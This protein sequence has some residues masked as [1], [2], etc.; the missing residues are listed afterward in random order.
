MTLNNMSITTDK[1]SK[2]IE[3]LNSYIGGDFFL[4]IFGQIFKSVIKQIQPKKCR[5]ALKY[6]AFG[7]K[8]ALH[9]NQRGLERTAFSSSYFI[10]NI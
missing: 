9:L 1:L 5:I 2:K 6:K 4:S 10:C 8:K 7:H 3:Q